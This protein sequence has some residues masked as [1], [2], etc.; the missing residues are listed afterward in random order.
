MDV[1]AIAKAIALANRHPDPEGYADAVQAAADTGVA[2]PEEAPAA[3]PTP[4]EEPP[5][6]QSQPL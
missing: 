4:A 3:E 1:K 5:V 2:Y 6:P